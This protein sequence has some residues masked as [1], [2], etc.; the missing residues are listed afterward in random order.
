M[1]TVNRIP[2]FIA[3]FHFIDATDFKISKEES[4]PSQTWFLLESTY[5]DIVLRRTLSKDRDFPIFEDVIE[6]EYM[7]Y[8]PVSGFTRCIYLQPDMEISYL[9]GMPTDVLYDEHEMTMFEISKQGDV[10]DTYYINKIYESVIRKVKEKYNL[11][12]QSL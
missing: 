8:E 3:H 7:Y 9:G 4:D 10:Q 5:V 2:Y 6:I 1:N 11:N 12:V